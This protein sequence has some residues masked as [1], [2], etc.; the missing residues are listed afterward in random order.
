[1]P[2]R[3]IVKIV[4]PV[5]VN[6]AGRYARGLAVGVLLLLAAAAL[7]LLLGVTGPGLPDAATLRLRLLRLGASLTVGAAL[8]MV[9]CAFQTLL[10]NPLADPY[11]LGVSG[12]AALGGTLALA[13]GVPAV[14]LPLAG[15]VL[16]LDGTFLFSFLG[17]LAAIGLLFGLVLR[18]RGAWLNP[19]ALLLA[20]FALNAFCS[21]L[22]LFVRVMVEST[23]TQEVLLWLIGNLSDARLTGPNL[24][25]FGLLL[26]LGGGWLVASAKQL[27]LLSLGDDAARSLGVNADRVRLLVFL[28]SSLMVALSVSLAGMVG[29]VGI[30]VP[31]AVR[32][33]FGAD[34]RFLL[35]L[36]ALYGGV[37]LAVS[38]AFTR[39]LFP[40]LHTELPVGLVSA[41]IGAPL[42]VWIL[43]REVRHA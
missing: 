39:A 23:K 36:S 38:D 12:G 43:R 41:V 37:F 33:L 21:A 1:L 40:W 15:L 27:N 26:L 32:L 11:I 8:S 34:L 31:Q 13:L 35:P 3:A 9:G 30:I 7:E 42:F 14:S 18:G 17:G 20:G 24:A 28:A 29:F 16:E 22:V 19:Y 10:Q 6:V 5:E 25:L 4:T 2:R